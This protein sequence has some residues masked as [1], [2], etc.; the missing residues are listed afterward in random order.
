VYSANITTLSLPYTHSSTR[1]I[2]S[3]K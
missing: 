3:H 1:Q 2:T